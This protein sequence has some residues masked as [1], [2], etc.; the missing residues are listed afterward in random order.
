MF[1]GDP[2]HPGIYAGLGV[3]EF[4][5]V[6]WR[7]RTNGDV[8]SSPAVVGGVVYVGSDD[9]N[10]DAAERSVYGTV[11]LEIQDRTPYPTSSCCGGRHRVLHKL[12]RQLLCGRR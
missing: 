2:V 10:L 1:R 4:H 5:E 9:G 8:I 6:R 7:F 12:R 11:A 3:P